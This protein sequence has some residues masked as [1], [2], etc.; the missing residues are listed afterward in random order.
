MA[1][2]LQRRR[3]GLG[4]PQLRALAESTAIVHDLRPFEAHLRNAGHGCP[5]SRI[6]SN[7]CIRK[8]REGPP[9]AEAS[10]HLP[11]GHISMSST[12]NANTLGQQDRPQ[13]L[14][15]SSPITLLHLES[16]KVF[17]KSCWQSGTQWPE[18][19]RRDLALV[20]LLHSTIFLHT[21]VK[22]EI[23]PAKFSCCNLA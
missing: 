12:N 6:D 20:P 5:S 18:Q 8:R 2:W 1:S 13:L 14:N 7:I 4:T 16:K 17:L 15:E 10:Q 11:W 22:T 9:F 19:V 21:C 23:N 3:K